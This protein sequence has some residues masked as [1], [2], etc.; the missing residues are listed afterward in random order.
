MICRD[1]LPADDSVNNTSDKQT[2]ETCVGLLGNICLQEDG[3]LTVVG[4]NQNLFLRLCKTIEMTIMSSP[5]PTCTFQDSGPSQ[6][7]P[8]LDIF[9]TSLSNMYVNPPVLA[10]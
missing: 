3:A 10:G 6:D 5:A 4:R 1:I 9:V 2:L 7:D 8:L